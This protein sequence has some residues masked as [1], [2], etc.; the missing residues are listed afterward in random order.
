MTMAEKESSNMPP[1]KETTQQLSQDFHLL[2]HSLPVAACILDPQGRIIGLNSEGENLL[3]WGERACIGRGLHD[4]LNCTIADR[5]ESSSVCPI[6]YVLQS[7]LPISAAQTYILTRSGALRPVEYRCAPL[8]QASRPHVIVTWRE[9]S[10]QLQMEHDLQRLASIPEENPNP[11]VEFDQSATLLYANSSMMELISRFGFDAEAF[12]A[13]LPQGLSSIIQACS[14]SGTASGGLLGTQGG[15][16]YEWTFFPVPRTTIVRGYGVD[17]TTHLRME[18]ELRQAKEAAEAANRAKSEFLA[19][20]SHE[21]RTPMNGVLGMTDLLL[22]TALTPEQRDY[23]EIAKRSASGLLDLVADILDFSSSEAGKLKLGSFDFQLREIIQHTISLFAPHTRQKGVALRYEV[24][25]DLPLTFRGDPHRLQ[26][27]L[28]NLV[29]NAVK[30]TDQ[31]AIAVEVKKAT[32]DRGGAQLSKQPGNNI[33]ALESS[34]L[35]EFVVRDTGIGIPVDR[36]DRLFKSFSQVDASSTRKYGGTGLG[37]A[38]SKQLIALMGGD[39]GIE[40]TPGYGST[41]WFTVRLTR[42]SLPTTSDLTQ[43]GQ[44]STIAPV[45][46]HVD[47]LPS[48]SD[49]RLLLVEDNP[50]NQKLALRLLKKFGYDADVAG[51]GQEALEMF[52]QQSY[53]AILMDCQMPKMDGFEATREIRRRESQATSAQDQQPQEQSPAAPSMTMPHSKHIPIIALTANAIKGDKERCLEAGMDDYLTKP[54]NPPELKATLERWL[55]CRL[56]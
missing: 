15:H 1:T 4:L 55:V 25:P 35:L 31:G 26:Q 45:A 33:A 42:S 28:V 44:P 16:S 12:P 29:G 3:E 37:L 7:G 19:T 56:C 17:L 47:N 9:V 27:I 53:D 32:A 48:P 40:S 34:C 50:I 41:F 14:Q 36:Q 22:M 54:I 43:S 20:V 51:D 6:A 49:S 39:I 5:E 2:L 30:F 24:A 38:I 10:H 8:T 13:I 23:A 18:E 11:I 52:G 21:L 46:R